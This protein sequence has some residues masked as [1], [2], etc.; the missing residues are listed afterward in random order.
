MSHEYLLSCSA[1][2]IVPSNAVFVFGRRNFV[3]KNQAEET[4]HSRE[5][6]ELRMCEN[7][8][9]RL[10]EPKRE[11]NSLNKTAGNNVYR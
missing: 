2:K 3:Q 8:A 1:A 11:K 6:H 7:I 10:S 4:Y 5:G 9:L